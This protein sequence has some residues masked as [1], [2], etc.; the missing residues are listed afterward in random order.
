[1]SPEHLNLGDSPRS[2]LC[3]ATKGEGE[4]GFRSEDFLI[5]LSFFCG[6]SNSLLGLK[7]AISSISFMGINF[8]TDW[9]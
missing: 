8:Y 6:V 4:I 2:N 1:M 7:G 3:L 5:A 9:E